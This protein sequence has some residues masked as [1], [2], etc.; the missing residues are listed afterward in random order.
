MT[1]RQKIYVEATS[2][3]SG[4]SPDLDRELAVLR[5][6]RRSPACSHCGTGHDRRGSVL[7]KRRDGGRLL[8]YVHGRVT[9]LPV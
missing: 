6:A 5:W 1:A 4:S 2:A 3:L 7:R 8:G 9:G